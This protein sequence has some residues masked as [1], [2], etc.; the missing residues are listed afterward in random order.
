MEFEPI[1]SALPIIVVDGKKMEHLWFHFASGS[2]G[3]YSF[4][5]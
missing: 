5:F 3:D 2:L 4:E 1:D